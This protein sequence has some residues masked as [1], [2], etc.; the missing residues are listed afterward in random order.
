MAFL[1]RAN[2]LLNLNGL[3]DSFHE[4]TP[5]DFDN[6]MKDLSKQFICCAF[7]IT[8]CCLPNVGLAQDSMPTVESVVEVIVNTDQLPVVE[9]MTKLE[10]LEAS[11]RFEFT[12]S[13]EVVSG[14]EYGNPI[15]ECDVNGMPVSDGLNSGTDEQ[16]VVIKKSPIGCKE[17]IK[18]L[19]QD[20]VWLV[21]ARD[22]V[23]GEVDLSMV[24]VTQFVGNEMVQRNLRQLT[25][26][27]ASG[28]GLVTVLYIHGNMTNKEYAASRG[29]QVY[30]NAFEKK[31]NH[32]VPVRYVIWAWK[33]EQTLPRYY[34]DYLVKS[35]RSLL[36]G[37]TFAATLNQFSDRN[38]IVFGYSL[39]V[40]VVL[41]AFDS[42]ILD[43]R[44]GD[45][46]RYQLALAAP[47]INAKFV[48]CNS[49]ARMNSPV[50]QT[51]VFTNRKDR[52]IRAAQAIIRR[53]NPTEEATIAG[54][55][56]AG[57]LH[58]GHVTAV[59]VFCETGRFHSIERY[60]RSMTLQSIMA[61]LVN[62]VDANKKAAFASPLMLPG[63]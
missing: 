4:S 8:V 7:L 10:M 11:E 9:P 35:N 37:E 20:E 61:K 51:F 43:R 38:I 60:T 63:Q 55:S 44:P 48:A 14:I 2:A 59:D 19:P 62:T 41:S 30:R 21:N 47:A 39:G 42:R 50:Q 57:K 52:A 5:A 31:A 46:S 17:G 34:K 36:V 56:D 26:A 45:A 27:H 54:L 6:A 1:V 24:R 16:C 22:C 33:S 12:E 40:Q 13:P 25:D 49:L 58:V 29:L 28:D 15:I 3:N 23:F 32:H 18:I 53:K